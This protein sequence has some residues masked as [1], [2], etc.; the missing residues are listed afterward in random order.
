[1]G[2]TDWMGVALDRDIAPNTSQAAVVNGR[3]VAIWRSDSAVN[4]WE[5]RCP[6][7]GMPFSFG[8]VKDRQIRCLY[9][10]WS[11]DGEGRCRLIPAHPSLTPPSPIRAKVYPAQVRYGIVWTQPDGGEPGDPGPEDEAEAEGWVGLRSFYLDIPAASVPAALTTALGSPAARKPAWPPGGGLLS[12]QTDGVELAVALQ[13]IDGD[14]AGIHVSVRS[15]PAL[16]PALKHAVSNRL[17]RFR[18][19]NAIA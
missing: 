8:F 19:A 4:V 16:T 17:E 6:H 12:F 10:G 11:F 1:M 13:S 7:R 3:S 14:R 15:G 5:N 2:Q 18:N 9:H